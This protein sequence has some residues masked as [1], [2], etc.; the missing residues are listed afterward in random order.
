MFTEKIK[1]TLKNAA[2]KLT[3]VAKRA[4]VAQVTID[5]FEGSSRNAESQMGWSRKTVAIGLK[6]L[7]TGIVCVDNYK[8]RGR[9][10]AEQR[11]TNL[12]EDIR[13]LIDGNSQTDATFQTTLR[14]S[15]QS[16]KKVREALIVQKGYLDSQLPTRQTIGDVLNRLN[17]RL[18]K[19]QKNKP[20]KKIPQTDAIFDNVHEANK[21]A[22]ENPSSLRI[23]IDC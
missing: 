17:Y 9:K 4:F 10:K 23:S 2:K 6:E 1:N 7:E 18:R 3:G 11:L 5:Y 20:L 15:R 14:Y 19:P 21:A 8:A 13:S 16:A 22:N 12:E